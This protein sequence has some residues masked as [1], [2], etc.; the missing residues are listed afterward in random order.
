MPGLA[1]NAAAAPRVAGSLS[2]RF[3]G[4][5]ALDLIAEAPGL[6]VSTGSACTSAALAPS[7]VL[8]AMGLSRAEAASTLRIGIGRFTSA[9]DMEAAAGA[10]AGAAARLA[11]RTPHAQR[12]EA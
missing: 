5:P 9:A 6:C 3:G 12:A 8:S 2:L 7:H 1:I 11:A 4:L 10:L